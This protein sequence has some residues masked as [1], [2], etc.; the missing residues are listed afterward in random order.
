MHGP[1]FMGNPLACSVAIRSI[2]LL[3]DS[4]WRANIL[5]IETELKNGLEPCRGLV[6][7]KDV[8]VLGAIGVVEL[9]QPVNM[10]RIQK[11]FVDNGVWVR[12]FGRL[13]YVMPPYIID[14]QDL[15]CLMEKMYLVVKKELA[16]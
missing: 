3:L 15:R 14:N 10:A 9:E 12:P 13:V 8:R 1:T 7:V 16:S 4:D 5:R 6:G 11:S 2:E